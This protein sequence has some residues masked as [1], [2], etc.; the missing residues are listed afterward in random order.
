M[1]SLACCLNIFYKCVYRYIL[2][3]MTQCRVNSQVYLAF[4]FAFNVVA[5]RSQLELLNHFSPLRRVGKGH[6]IVPVIPDNQ[7]T[8]SGIHETEFCDDFTHLIMLSSEWLD[9]I[10]CIAIKGSFLAWPFYSSFPVAFQCRK[11]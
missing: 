2:Q 9:F 6:I 11:Q 4:T 10:F 5:T 8:T 3:C 1:K 7:S